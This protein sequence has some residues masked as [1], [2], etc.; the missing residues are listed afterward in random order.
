MI[1]PCEL[2]RYQPE[3]LGLR[4]G[5]TRV[6]QIIWNNLIIVIIDK[7]EKSTGI[8]TDALTNI[9][10][11]NVLDFSSRFSSLLEDDFT[12]RDCSDWTH[13]STE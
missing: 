3:Y 10:E 9:L 7:Q 6:H 1:P 12:L 11:S 4:R 8:S 2:L 13:M 5:T